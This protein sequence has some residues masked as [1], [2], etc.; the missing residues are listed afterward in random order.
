M[1]T[2]PAE[3]QQRRS[4]EKYARI[5]AAAGRLLADTAYEEL[6]TKLIAATAGVSVGVLYRYFPDKEAI[7]AALV[8]DWLRIDVEIADR[9]TADPLPATLDVLL[10]D[11]V[12]AYA[13]RFRVLSGYRRVR[14]QVPSGSALRAEATRTDLAIADRLRAAL[15]RGYGAPDDDVTALRCRLAVE[16]GGQLLDIAFRDQPAGDPAVL[17]ETTVLMGRYLAT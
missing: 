14:Y 3:P 4:R 1:P 6:G 11:L 2:Q 12:D 5:V 10:G 9:I 15:V 13:D 8:R 16:V 7:V 17:A